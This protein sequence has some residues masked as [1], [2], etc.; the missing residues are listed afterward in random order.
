MQRNKN[1]EKRGKQQW[2]RKKLER[3]K[4]SNRK[5]EKAFIDKFR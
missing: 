2:Q 3:V 1:K 4:I 5:E